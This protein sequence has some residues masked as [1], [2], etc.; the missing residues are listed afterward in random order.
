MAYARVFHAVCVCSQFGSTPLLRAAENGRLEVVKVLLVAGADKEARGRVSPSIGLMA[1]M[2]SLSLLYL[3]V[4]V[5]C[6]AG[7]LL[8]M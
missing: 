1:C 7:Y 8:D 2:A 5:M 4:C 6:N 3:G